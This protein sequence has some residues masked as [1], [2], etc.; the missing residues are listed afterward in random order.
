M[1]NLRVF[2]DANANS[3]YDAGVD[4]ANARSTR[5]LK[6]RS[7]RV[8]VL[9]DVPLTATNNQFANV[10]LAARAAVAGTSGATLVM[11]SAAA[12]NPAVVDVVFADVGAT[13]RDGI[14]EASDQYAIAS[15]TLSVA[16]TSTV[17][18]DPFNITTNP[19]AIPGAVVQY[20]ITV[21][22]TGA[23]AATGVGD[24]RSA[25]CEHDVRARAIHGI[26]RRRSASGRHARHAASR[27]RRLI[28]TSMAASAMHSG[29]L[30]VGAPMAVS[31]VNAA[32]NRH[33]A[34]PRDDQLMIATMH[35]RFRPCG[36]S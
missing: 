23:S 6:M 31:T 22:N 14:H 35:T 18:S 12:D 11:Q 3:V 4:T 17:I 19:K 28:P 13:A 21:T 29:Q 36:S 32:A 25:A 15:A 26:D 24:Q 10:Q 8:F 33:R 5:S 27:R 1:N 9:A 20:A 2:V 30:V 7:S 16:K 34:L